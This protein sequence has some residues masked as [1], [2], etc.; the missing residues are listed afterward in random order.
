MEKYFKFVEVI[1]HVSRKAENMADTRNFSSYFC[2][3]AIINKPLEIGNT[4]S[5][6]KKEHE[7]NEVY[8]N[9]SL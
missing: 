7:S 8:E 5:S 9:F 1:F 4:K 2:L 3:M 6:K